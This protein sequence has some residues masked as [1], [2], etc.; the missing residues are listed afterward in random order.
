LIAYLHDTNRPLSGVPSH[1]LEKKVDEFVDSSLGIF[2]VRI[3]DI[4]ANGIISADITSAS[5]ENVFLWLDAINAVAVGLEPADISILAGRSPLSLSM[6]ELVRDDA[7]VR[8]SVSRLE[9]SEILETIERLA[10][11]AHNAGEA[12]R[13]Q[14]DAYIQQFADA[15]E[16]QSSMEYERQKHERALM[17]RLKL[18]GFD[19]PDEVSIDLPVAPPSDDRNDDAFNIGAGSGI[20]DPFLFNE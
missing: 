10:F 11:L 1:L 6:A 4:A 12:Q 2:G 18:A 17:E 19:V 5:R 15:P 16:L 7:S 20:A 9:I 13:D 14:V 8:N 3:F